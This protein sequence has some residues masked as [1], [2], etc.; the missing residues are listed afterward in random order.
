M[1]QDSNEMTAITTASVKDNEGKE[2]I[3]VR[4]DEKVKVVF[5]ESKYHKEGAIEDIHP[6]LAAKFVAGG[7]AT[8]H[9]EATDEQIKRVKAIQKGLPEK[10]AKKEK[11]K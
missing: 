11:Q 10:A 3:Q 8:L 4:P 2:G 6:A 1:A 9:S 7:I 5:K